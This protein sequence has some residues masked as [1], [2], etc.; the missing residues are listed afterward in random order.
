MPRAGLEVHRGCGGPCRVR[1]ASRMVQTDHH[2]RRD[3]ARSCWQNDSAA[4]SLGRN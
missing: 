4:G 2:L 3:C 1:R